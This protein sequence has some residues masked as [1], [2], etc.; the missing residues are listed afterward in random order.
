MKYIFYTL[1]LIGFISCDNELDVVEDFKDIPVVYGFISLSDTAQYIRVERAF[2]DESTSALELAQIPDSLYYDNPTVTLEHVNSGNQYQLNRVDG[3]L[4]G[5][6]RED[7]AF[8]Q[9][10]NY[11]YKIRSSEMNLVAEDEYKLIINRGDDT[12]LIE[13]QTTLLSGADLKVP[14]VSNGSLVSFNSIDFTT[15][16]WIASPNA[17]IFN[18]IIDF[19]YRERMA[20]TS[21]SFEAK[22]V[23]WTAAKNL[24]KNDD[25]D[26]VSIEIDGANFY[27]FIKGA[28][29]EVEG[30]ERRFDD[31]TI[32]ISSGGAEIQEFVQIGSANL[33]I[34]STQDPP[35]FSNIE[36][37]RGVFSSTYDL[38]L[39]NAAVTNQT[40]DSIR[41]G[42][43]TK[44]LGFN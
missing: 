20:N 34:T 4:E 13:T 23:T 33:G 25:S 39:P 36:G 9:S 15:F 41:G 10:P 42:Q 40:L 18:V 16:T 5:Y 22:T 29:P 31:L 8:A 28:I 11:L 37:G 3:N 2:I 7:G 14:N 21:N 43:F 19:N 38:V 30:I 26:R 27:T 35:F 1:L 44:D 24:R 6:V 32:Y 12:D 17:R